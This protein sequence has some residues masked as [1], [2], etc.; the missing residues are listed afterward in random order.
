MMLTDATKFWLITRK[1]CQNTLA[2]F[3][4]SGN[5]IHAI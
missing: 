3:T 2:E 5:R 1:Q 4:E